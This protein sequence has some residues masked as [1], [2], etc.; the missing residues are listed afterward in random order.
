MQF[1]IYFYAT[2]FSCGQQLKITK[3][4]YQK[5]ILDPPKTHDKKNL[6]PRNIQEKNLGP[7]K[8]PRGALNL[9]LYLPAVK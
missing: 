5:N 6:Y 7:T 9:I 3:L 4:P 1:E 8:Y 2:F